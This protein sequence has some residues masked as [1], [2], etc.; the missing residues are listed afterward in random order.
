MHV[1]LD[2][3]LLADAREAVNLTRLDDED[4]TGASLE[5]FAI[6]VV[7]TAALSHELNLVVGMTVRAGTLPRQRAQQKHRNVHVT[8]VGADEVVRAPLE[9]QILL[10]NA[11]HR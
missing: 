7:P 2:E 11:M 5:L 3:R 9:R 1:D 6:H 8:L 4:V 10:A